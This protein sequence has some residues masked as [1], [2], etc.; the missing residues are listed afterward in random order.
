MLD[1]DYGFAPG[2]W[3]KWFIGLLTVYAVLTMFPENAT[4][5]KVGALF[6]IAAFAVLRWK[7]S[8]SHRD[9]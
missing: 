3:P 8:K 6:V 9:K 5:A 1:H 7:I 2:G 4:A